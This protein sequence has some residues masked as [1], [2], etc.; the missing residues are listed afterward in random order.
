MFLFNETLKIVR[1][2]Y[3]ERTNTDFKHHINQY[4]LSSWQD[5]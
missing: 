3:T 4:I 1:M 5:D 2:L